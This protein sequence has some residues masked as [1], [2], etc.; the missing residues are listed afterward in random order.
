[1]IRDPVGVALQ[2]AQPKG[3]DVHAGFIK[4]PVA[5]RTDHVPL[6]VAAGSYVVPAD[7]VSSLGE[8]NSLSGALVL[9][10]MMKSKAGIGAQFNQ[11]PYRPRGRRHFADGG[12]VGSPVDIMAAGGEYV[13]PPDT[14]MAI[15]QGDLTRGH[16]IL[17]QW[18]K[19]RRQD[20]IKTLKKLPGP[21]KD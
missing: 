12:G 7:I 18:V 11:M 2:A 21:A 4:L 20:H 9:D 13:F 15:G 5:G 10:K 3:P 17:D 14:V 8:G 19:N 1:M 6:T 16:D